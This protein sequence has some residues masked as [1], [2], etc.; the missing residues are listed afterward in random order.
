MRTGCYAIKSV[1]GGTAE[2][3]NGVVS[4]YGDGPDSSTMFGVPVPQT[5]GVRAP[6]SSRD[7]VATARIIR[8]ALDQ[9]NP[10][11]RPRCSSDRLNISPR[12]QSAARQRRA[13]QT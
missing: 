11:G 1:L 9:T 12:G 2:V 8:A 4:I 3:G 5:L 13:G 10:A 7:P 6:S